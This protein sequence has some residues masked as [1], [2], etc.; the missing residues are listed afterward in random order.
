[1]GDHLRKVRLDRE[2][3]QADVAEILNASEAM[4]TAW[5]LNRNEPTAKFAKRIIEFLGYVPFQNPESL[6]KRLYLARL[7]SGKTQEEVSKEIGVD[8]S[9]LRL[10][11]LGVRT[12]FRKTREKIEWFL[13]EA[14]VARVMQI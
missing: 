4:V 12:P 1:M 13:E 11:E 14:L 10:I 5:E 3:L 9:N 7:I 2:L 6:A 8:E